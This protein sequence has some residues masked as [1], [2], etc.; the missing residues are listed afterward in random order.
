DLPRFENAEEIN[1]TVQE[2]KVKGY[3][4]EIDGTEITNHYTPGKTSVNVVKSWN[5]NNNIANRPDSITINLFANGEKIDSVELNAKNN[6]QADFMELDEYKDGKKI[7]YTITEDKV[8]GFVTESINGNAE[9]GCVVTNKPVEDPDTPTDPH[10]EDPSGED[11]TN[12]ED[13]KDD[14]VLPKT[15]E[16]VSY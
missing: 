1:Y 7:I 15:G 6:W 8:N 4:T 5:D 14:S 13:P 9:D 10:S 12:P 2:D 16:A 3:S 11:P